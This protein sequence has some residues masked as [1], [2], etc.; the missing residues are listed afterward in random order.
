M[1][2]ITLSAIF[3]ILFSYHVYASDIKQLIK[4]VA[5][6]NIA[7][8]AAHGQKQAQTTSL[9]TTNNLS[10]PEVEFGHLWGAKN[11]G[12][13]WDLKI[14]QSFDWPGIYTQRQK[15]IQY[16]NQA[17]SFAYDSEV[18]NIML[19]I[20][21]TMLDIINARKNVALYT[22]ILHNVDSL[23]IIY[24]RGLELGEVTRLDVN[25]LKIEH[26]T[27]TRN[28]ADASIQLAEAIERLTE[29]NG[30][31]NSND[32]ATKLNDYPESVILP[33][34]SYLNEA[35]SYN[36]SLL[37][38]KAMIVAMAHKVSTTRMSNLPSFKLGYNHVNELGE[39][40]NGF[41]VSMS[42]PFFSNRNKVKAAESDVESYEL[43][44]KKISTQISSE[45]I[46]NRNNAMAL[47]TEIEQYR[48]IVESNENSHLL[49]KA[50]NGGQ[51]TLT[52]YLLQTRYFLDAKIDYLKL[53]YQYNICIARLEQY[54]LLN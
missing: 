38:T 17:A 40:F 6:N 24:N 41:S 11:I 52:E 2:R 20:K 34:E 42:L 3:L 44:S 4:E 49:A 45:I 47:L 22:A 35:Y 16:S 25:K 36:P 10:D 8:K 18:L 23:T 54:S 46:T 9:S 5:N 48:P 19:D 39:H 51:I 53:L 43:T 27:A 12:N 28:L 7:I 21:I 32:I 30:G 26:I 15:E 29:L 1:N 50:L 37:S 13:K 31:I 33:F 14:S